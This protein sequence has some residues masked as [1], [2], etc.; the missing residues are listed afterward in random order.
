[1][2]ASYL[3]VLRRML[4]AGCGA[5]YAMLPVSDPAS[6]EAGTVWPARVVVGRLMLPVS[7]PIGAVRWNSPDARGC[8]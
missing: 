2:A 5:G 1:M 6:C 7:R 3:T 8:G 4:P